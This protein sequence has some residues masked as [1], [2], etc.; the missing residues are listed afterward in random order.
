M[1]ESSQAENMHRARVQ[2]NFS[3]IKYITFG[4]ASSIIGPVGQKPSQIR[5]V[6]DALAGQIPLPQ[7]AAALSRSL[8]HVLGIE[9][10]GMW[11]HIPPLVKLVVEFGDYSWES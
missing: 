3:P 2:A 11:Q 10:E 8:C 1:G 4:D 9:L 7:E 5:S 6:Y